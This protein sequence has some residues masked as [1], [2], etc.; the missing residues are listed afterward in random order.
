MYMHKKVEFYRS[1]PHMHM[2][3]YMYMYMNITS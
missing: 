2:Y 1:D 3:M